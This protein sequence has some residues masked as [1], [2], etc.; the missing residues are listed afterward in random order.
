MPIYRHSIIFF[1]YIADPYLGIPKT[2]PS[3]QAECRLQVR[4]HTYLDQPTSPP[5]WSPCHC[6]PFTPPSLILLFLAAILFPSVHS[7]FFPITTRL[8]KFPF[9]NCSVNNLDCHTFLQLVLVL[10]TVGAIYCIYKTQAAPTIK[11]KYWSANHPTSSNWKFAKSPITTSFLLNPL[12]RLVFKT[13]HFSHLQ[14]YLQ[15]GKLPL[16]R[17]SQ[18]HTIIRVSKTLSSGC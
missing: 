17:C 12:A 16:F 8:A 2:P 5:H 9:W 11:P 3:K 18:A 7:S 15:N 10:V 1:R 14:S 4:P 13:P 6:H